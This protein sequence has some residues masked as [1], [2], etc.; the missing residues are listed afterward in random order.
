MFC[1]E[2]IALADTLLPIIYRQYIIA[3]HLK[4]ILKPYVKTNNFH[5]IGQTR[6]P[7]F[8]TGLVITESESLD[9]LRLT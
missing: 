5:C 3:P 7:S 4:R 1:K 8:P 9:Q 6:T 2:I